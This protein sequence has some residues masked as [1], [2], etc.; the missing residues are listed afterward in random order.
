MSSLPPAIQRCAR[1]G[2]NPSIVVTG[3]WPPSNEAVRRFSTDS[4]QNPQGWIGGNWEG[5]GY[6]VFSYFP[7]FTPPNCNNCG[8]GSGDLQVDYQD[9]TADFRPLIEQHEPVAVV[10]MSRG[11]AGNDWELEMNQYNRNSWF[12]DFC[13]PFQPDPSPPDVSVPAGFLRLSQLPVQ[14]VVDAINA[15]M[16]GVNGYICFAGD[17]G[18]FLSEFVAYQGVWYQSDKRSPA[19]PDWCIS[20]GHVHVGATVSWATAA[21]V[22]EITL[23]AVIADL[24][25]AIASTICQPSV[26][27]SGPGTATLTVCGE[28]MATGGFS[29]LLFDG[30]PP[31]AFAA[32]VAGTNDASP[33][34]WKMGLVIP[35]PP[36]AVRILPVDAGGRCLLRDLPGGMGPSTIFTQVVYQDASAPK[37]WGF[38]NT[39]A[40]DL[41]P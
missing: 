33:F 23:R 12:G 10:T 5:R 27:P 28:V 25:A 41:L 40:I 32:L 4:T 6:D 3:Y 7:E 20:A 13:A 36:L 1:A 16:I 39:V 15:A 18:G 31:S 38:T 34:Q 29:D 35:F 8:K 14:A 11:N 2:T 9:T 30:A 37:G 22:L 26:T 21:Q 19:L 17:G 24:D